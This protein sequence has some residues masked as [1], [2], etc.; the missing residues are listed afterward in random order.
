MDEKR[1]KRV[2]DSLKDYYRNFGPEKVPVTA[3]S[4]WILTEKII[5]HKEVYPLVANIIE[6]GEKC[7]KPCGSDLEKFLNLKNWLRGTA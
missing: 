1:W 5:S 4:Y 2:G 3:F 6:E 7:L